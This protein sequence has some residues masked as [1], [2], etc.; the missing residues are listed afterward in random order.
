[1]NAGELYKAGQLQAA[2]DA[3]LQEVKNDPDN[4]TKR[5]FLFELL[6]FAGDLD[7]AQRQLDAVRVDDPDRQLSILAY[8]Q[9]LDSERAR[10]KLLADGHPPK[11]LGESQPEHIRLRLEAVTCL[12]SARPADAV[13]LLE[14]ANE[15]L[16]QLD[17]YLN[18]IAFK[19]LRDCDDLL[20]GVLE[21]YARGAYYWVPLEQVFQIVIQPPKLTR[22]LLWLPAQ[23][24]M[25]DGQ[26]GGVFLP[27]LYC[28]SH[29]YS[30]DKIR[31]GRQTDWKATDGGPTRGAG[32]KT[33]IA[34]E[35]GVPVLEWRHLAIAPPGGDA[36]AP[37]ASG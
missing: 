24:Q 11:F 20:A 36:A 32:L 31:L 35:E 34:G 3:Q 29:E 30:D 15:A 9:L 10:R 23:L 14:R 1:M 16:E 6:A 37:P 19:G 8:R 27:T 13:P 12:R 21:V 5:V 26:E 4:S 2:V 22:E 25:V 28:G 33:F 7:R 17:G 18:G